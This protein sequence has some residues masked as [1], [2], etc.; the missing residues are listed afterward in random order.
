MEY[1]YCV[2]CRKNVPASEIASTEI[3]SKQERYYNHINENGDQLGVGD[4]YEYHA[5]DDCGSIIETYDREG[6]GTL[7][8]I[9]EQ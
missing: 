5:G 2:D 3:T 6:A 9:W 8:E 7:L 1:K 4:W